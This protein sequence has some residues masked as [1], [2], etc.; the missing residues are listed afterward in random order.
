MNERTNKRMN[1][2]MIVTRVSGVLT[3]ERICMFITSCLVFISFNP[4]FNVAITIPAYRLLQRRTGEKGI[5]K[6][7][8]DIISLKRADL[9]KD[10]ETE[11]LLNG[12]MEKGIFDFEDKKEIDAVKHRY[13]KNDK[14]LTILLAKRPDAF[15]DFI[16]VLQGGTQWYFAVNLLRAGR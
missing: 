14:F 7:H 11:K 12:L 1:E 15:Y 16:E 5:T 4:R 9:R 2:L 3:E 10:L 13:D 8:E 6:M